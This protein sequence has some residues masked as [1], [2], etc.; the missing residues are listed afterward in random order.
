MSAAVDTE[1]GRLYAMD[2]ALLFKWIEYR[3]YTQDVLNFHESDARMRIMSAPART[4]KSYSAAAELLYDAMPQWQVV[5]GKVYYHE[6]KLI[7]CVG[8]DYSQIKEFDY[9]YKWL[10]TDRQRFGF[11]YKLARKAKAKKKGDLVIHIQWGRSIDGEMVETIIEGKSAK[12]KASLQSEEIYSCVMSEA[13]ELDE[14]ILPHYLATRCHNLILPTTPKPKAA[15]IRELIDEGERD[16]AHSIDHFHYAIDPETRTSPN[17]KFD[18]KRFDV[19]RRRAES[20][21]PTG[22]AEDDPFFAEQFLGHWVYYEGRILPFRHQRTPG[23][24][25]H[26]FSQMPP[27]FRLLRKFVSVDYGFDHKSA[28]LF[29]FVTRGGL[30]GIFD[31]IVERESH[32]S[33]FVDA[34]QERVAQWGIDVNYYVGDPSRPEVASLYRERGLPVWDRGGKNALRD[35]AA[36]TLRLIDYLSDDELTGAPCLYVHER[37]VETIN[38][39]KKLR[40]KEGFSGDEF[41]KA[42]VAKGCDD[43]CFDA[44]RY[45][46]QTRPEPHIDFAERVP[47]WILHRKSVERDA[48]WRE[49]ATRQPL[50]GAVAGMVMQ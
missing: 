24:V 47:W 39:W 16:P 40:R 14:D 7:W 45:G 10:V 46:I 22:R 13:A 50:S 36:G 9:L 38:E 17:P 33:Q 18:W 23:R 21:S 5:D 31:E 41:A 20:R 35:R 8:P 25:H 28:A 4:S 29:W 43:D 2:K 48:Y 11:D 27:D 42:A 3:I 37:C 44:A 6:S 26:T 34:I 32:P 12:E 30:L 49:S 19:A 1:E 15:W